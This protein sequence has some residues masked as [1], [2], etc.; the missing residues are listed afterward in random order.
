MPLLY[1]SLRRRF[2]SPTL[3]IIQVNGGSQDF[4]S[5]NALRIL[6]R[7]M[8]IPVIPNQSSLP[9]AYENFEDDGGNG[10]GRA[11]LLSS[12]DREKPGFDGER[13]AV[14]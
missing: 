10:D 7:R 6:G 8:R 3:S 12:S 4:N 2:I 9:M 11:R 5:V 13:V 1:W 14:S